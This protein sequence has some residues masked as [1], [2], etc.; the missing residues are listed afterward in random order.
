VR[1]RRRWRPQRTGYCICD[2]L[3]YQPNDFIH[4][5][6]KPFVPLPVSRLICGSAAAQWSPPQ[7]LASTRYPCMVAA[8]VPHLLIPLFQTRTQAALHRV[9]S[10]FPSSL[11]LETTSSP[12]CRR[13]QQENPLPTPRRPAR[14]VQL[15]AVPPDR[16]QP[17]RQPMSDKA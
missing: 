6:L 5:R 1:P 4:N 12:S 8:L 13:L 9:A 2:L 16:A 7:S 10:R 17:L 11:I 15:I 14:D 3:N